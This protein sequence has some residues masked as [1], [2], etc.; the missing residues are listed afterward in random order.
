M[1][2]EDVYS[3]LIKEVNEYGGFIWHISKYKSHYIKFRDTRL[4]SIRIADHKGRDKYKYK[5][6]IDADKSESEIKQLTAEISFKIYE[7]TLSIPDFNKNNFIVYDE[8][9]MGY[10]KVENMQEYKK[11]ILKRK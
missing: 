5:Y 11:H 7:H 3:L 4:G 2:P 10:I 1:K 8:N 9:I 6:D